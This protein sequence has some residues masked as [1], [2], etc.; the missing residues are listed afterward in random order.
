MDAQELASGDIRMW[1]VDGTLHFKAV[2]GTDP[3]ELNTSQLEELIEALSRF[4]TRMI[5]LDG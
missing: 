5:E 1:L 4:R 2:D 3:V